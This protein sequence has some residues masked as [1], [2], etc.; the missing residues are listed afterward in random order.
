VD[1]KPA[2]LALPVVLLVLGPAPQSP[3]VRHFNDDRPGVLPPGLVLASMRQPSP[4]TWTV[5]RTAAN[6]YLLHAANA[7]HAGGF[8]LALAPPPTPADLLVSARVRLT[9]GS[10]A[11]GVV[12]NYVDG[13]HY[14][15]AVLDLRRGELIWYRV[16]D[17]N[18]VR[19]EIEDDLEL[20]GDAWHTLKVTTD[21]NRVSVWLGGIRVLQDERRAAPSAVPVLAGVLAAGDSEA[22]FD[23]LRIE[24]A[25]DR[26]RR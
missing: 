16:A 26:R 3:S 20:D 11:G 8:S 5:E 18:K 6:G 21:G 7:A 2:L 22:Q 12:W 14:S 23:D 15:S 13:D 17:G 24:A 10:R 1:I 19:V 4:G 9:G 25:P